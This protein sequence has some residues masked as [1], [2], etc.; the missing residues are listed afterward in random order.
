MAATA[1]VELS[2][3][4]TSD[5]ACI[6]D[7]GPGA[8]RW[9]AQCMIWRME[10]PTAVIECAKR[11]SEGILTETLQQQLVT[12]LQ[13][14][15]LGRRFAPDR[16]YSLR[17]L[18]LLITEAER[19]AG[20]GEVWEELYPIPFSLPPIPHPSARASH[21]TLSASPQPPLHPA[22]HSTAPASSLWCFHTYAL[23]LPF[24]SRCPPYPRP[25]A[26][27]SDGLSIGSDGLSNGSDGLSNGSDGPSNG[28]YALTLRVSRDMLKGGTGCTAWPASFFLAEALLAHASLLLPSSPPLEPRTAPVCLELGSGC[29]LLGLCLAPLPLS[30]LILTD[31]S[32]ES[33]ANLCANLT[34]NGL[35]FTS[36]A[37]V[38]P[39]LSATSCQG[40]QHGEK[41]QGGLGSDGA[42]MHEGARVQDGARSEH[43]GTRADEGARVHVQQLSWEDM[44]PSLAS[45]ISADVILGA[46][47]VYDPS[48][49]PALADALAA[50]LSTSAQTGCTERDTWQ[51]ERPAGMAR[52]AGVTGNA[53][54]SSP[55]PLPSPPYALIASTR[56]NPLTMAAF[57]QALQDRGLQATDVAQELVPHSHSHCDPHSGPHSRSRWFH[58]LELPEADRMLLHLIQR[59]GP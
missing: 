33:L 34:I 22:S 15:P 2:A 39:P 21:H 12:M 3:P 4:S 9:A 57:L 16:T 41:E 47:I 27:G 1:A 25:P 40:K 28:S 6:E 10:P 14:H 43:E 24:P 44:T 20:G 36:D 19:G 49:V 38:S 13:S 58:H 52:A 30:K 11:G 29:G 37:A 46:D 23:R 31:A 59:Q 32:S 53:A 26:N 7:S 5:C 50:L 54:S 42:A 51:D 45:T 18:K 56:R 48:V 35:Q 17:V 8:W 55:I